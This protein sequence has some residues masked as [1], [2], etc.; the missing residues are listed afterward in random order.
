MT[1]VYEWKNIR[2]GEIIEHSHWSIPPD[3]S[4]DWRRIFS[5]GVGRVEGAGSSPALPSTKLKRSKK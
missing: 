1:P 5:F 3:E 2:T 4:G